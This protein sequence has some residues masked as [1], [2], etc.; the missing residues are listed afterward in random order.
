MSSDDYWTA[1]E[2]DD[3]ED[4]FVGF[5]L[6]TSPDGTRWY[7]PRSNHV[8]EEHYLCFPLVKFHDHVGSINVS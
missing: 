8:L 2:S 6:Y 5:Y 4:V 3:E 7:L 1:E